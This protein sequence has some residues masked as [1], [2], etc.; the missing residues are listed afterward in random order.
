MTN[1]PTNKKLLATLIIIIALFV[2]GLLVGNKKSG[3]A[4][5]NW[6]S[7]SSA[8]SQAQTA[9]TTVTITCTKDTDN[10]MKSPAISYKQKSRLY[11]NDNSYLE[12]VCATDLDITSRT[13]TEYACDNG[14]PVI[15]LVT[16]GITN[17]SCSLGRCQ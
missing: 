13:L 16:C 4:N 8:V 11:F 7:L 6:P 12:D 14:V 1:Q 5:L 15:Q 2:V 10:T 9:T 3:Q 17:N